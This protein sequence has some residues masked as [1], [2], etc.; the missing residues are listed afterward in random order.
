MAEEKMH[1]ICNA[2]G[3]YQ[4]RQLWTLYVASWLPNTSTPSVRDNINMFRIFV[5]AVVGAIAS[6]GISKQVNVVVPEQHVQ[7]GEPI[8]ID[9]GYESAGYSGGYDSGIQGHIVADSG[10]GSNGAELASLAHSS[11][12][13]AKHAVQSQHTAGSQAAFGAKSNLANTAFGAA[14]TAQ[15]ALVGKQAIA[16]SLKKQAIEAQE[17]L[18]AEISQYHQLEAVAQATQ[19]ASQDAQN[20][21]NLTRPASAKS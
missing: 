21:L 18:Q 13:Q 16:Q 11:A 19:Q 2:S 10:K 4:I 12:V 14:Q 3:C 17:Q 5:F 8:A 1:H 6:A 9:Q 7:Y 15:A 20:Q